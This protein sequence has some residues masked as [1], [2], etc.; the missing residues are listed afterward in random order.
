MAGPAST[1][2]VAPTRLRQ[3]ALVA[4]NLDET[5]RLMTK[6][7]GV[8]VIYEDPL[9][10]K[11]GLKNFLLPLGGEIIEVCSPFQPGTTAGRLINKRGGDGG[12]MIIMQTGDAS[13]RRNYIESNK[14]GRVIWTHDSDHSVAVQYHPKGVKGGVIP[15][16]DSHTPTK[17]HPNPVTERFSPWHALGP[18]KNY[19]QHL[20]AMKNASALKLVGVVCR[21]EAGDV[22]A[23]AASRQWEELFGVG[24]VRDLVGFTN[25]RLGFV[26]GLPGQQEGIHSITVGVEGKE[27]MEK[28]LAAAREEGLCGDGYFTMCG[29]RWYLTDTGSPKKV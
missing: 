8:D 1:S 20:E 14:L 28:I 6:I 3:V 21:L 19:P 17:E 18:I 4:K 5:R 24:R 7:F 11:W 26:R 15:E 25:A 29:I 16:L 2:K 12:Y 22:D 27:R 23:E 13:A 9:V 10:A